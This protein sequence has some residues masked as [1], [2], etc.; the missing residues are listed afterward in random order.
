MVAA[1]DIACDPGAPTFNNGAPARRTPA[2]SDTARLVERL[3]PDVVLVLGDDQYGSSRYANYLG[4]YDPTWG[5]FK[6]RSHPTPGDGPTRRLLPLLGPPRP[7]PRACPGA[8]TVSEAGIALT[9]QQLQR[10]WRLWLRLASSRVASTHAGSHSGVCRKPP[11]GT[12]RAGSTDGRHGRD[13]ADLGAA[14]R[15]RRRA[16]PERRG[17]QLRALSAPRRERPSASWGRSP[18]HRQ[19]R[20]KSL[21]PFTKRRR[22]SGT[23]AARRSECSS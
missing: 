10:Q 21:T 23:E 15:L 11:S 12:S 5:R 4:S 16:R 18:I 8:G 9:E 19:D 22:G 17:T 3:E 2:G 14:L 6:R 7:P 20:R 1:G 13:G